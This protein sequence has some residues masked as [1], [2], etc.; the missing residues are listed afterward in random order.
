MVNFYFIDIFRT[1]FTPPSTDADPGAF[2]PGYAH[3]KGWGI[4]QAMGICTPE[5]GKVSIQ[6]K[7]RSGEAMVG[8]TISVDFHQGEGG[9]RRDSLGR[10]G[11]NTEGC[12]FCQ[13]IC[14][15]GKNAGDKK[16]RQAEQCEHDI[17]HHE[18]GT[19]AIRDVPW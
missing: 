3:T 18:S 13:G 14:A 9:E 11:R 10:R 4:S 19:D 8:E 2:P 7:A 6:T 1:F 12:L 15:K 16:C 5:T 17:G